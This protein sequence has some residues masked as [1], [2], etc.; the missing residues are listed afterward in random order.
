[1]KKQLRILCITILCLTT[2]FLRAQTE[3][4]EGAK[5]F[6]DQL[7][8]SQ[9][10]T[11]PGNAVDGD[12]TNYALMRTAIGVL[13]SSTLLLG[14]SQVGPAGA[15]AVLEFQNDNGGINADVLQSMSLTLYDSDGMEVAQQNGYNI[16]DATLVQATQH[17]L[18]RL[19]AG[20]G[21]KDI[22]AI[23]IKISGLASVENRIRIFN[24]WLAVSCGT[25]INGSS[26]FAENNVQNSGNAVSVSKKDFAT[27]S[28]PILNGSS[29]LDLAFPQPA[30][31]GKNVTFKLGEGTS[32]LSADLLQH[33]T[34]TV[35]NT[36]GGVVVSKSDF[37]LGDA[38][39]LGNGKFNLTVETPPGNYQVAR[40]RITLTTFV[41]VLTTLKV[42]VLVGRLGCSAK[43]AQVVAS[44]TLPLS[45][46]QVY[47]NPFHSYASLNIKGA[48][49]SVYRITITDKAG[50]IAE[51][52][53]FT[54]AGTLRILTNAAPGIYFVKISSGT[55]S[56]TRKVIKL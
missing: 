47:P 39:V 51:E 7:L 9:G 18:I 13:N 29:Y 53:Q 56:E 16:S 30:D 44:E 17:Y 43:S 19:K 52:H 4:T 40:G 42:Y 50:N 38:E 2:S 14:W 35:Y 32:V 6:A 41:N 33:I 48:L 46:S 26:V 37:V 22:A 15:T 12:R 21:A 45:E 34:V 49:Q 31:A 5:N 10:V 24:S 54:G 8:S 1:M 36:D 28:P 3:R 27:L 55:Y 25:T 20:G 23:K 11:N